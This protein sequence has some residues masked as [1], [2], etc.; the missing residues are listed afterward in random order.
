MCAHAVDL[1]ALHGAG[2]FPEFKPLKTVLELELQ[3]WKTTDKTS[4]DKL[5]K[6]VKK[7]G[8]TLTLTDWLTA[9]TTFGIAPDAI[10]EHVNQA[11]P[12]DLYSKI[13]EQQEMN[14]VKK[15]AA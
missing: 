2:S 8:G 7:S 13:A 3:R 14:C 11:I 10:A 9:A 12:A 5:D 6:L 1:E 15:L 4:H